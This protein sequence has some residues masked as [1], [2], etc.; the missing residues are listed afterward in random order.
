[1]YFYLF[2]NH[3]IVTNNTINNN[4]RPCIQVTF[5][6]GTRQP[7][8]Q[9]AATE[10]ARLGGDTEWM[11]PGSVCPGIGPS[12][13]CQGSMHGACPVPGACQPRHTAVRGSCL[14]KVKRLPALCPAPLLTG[15]GREKSSGLA[16][17]L[18]LV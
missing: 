17:R 7:F 13:P 11:G 4:S 6:G 9:E 14:L 10:A 8:Q 3:K 15:L 16:A 5:G 18:I 12:S 2:F 1:M